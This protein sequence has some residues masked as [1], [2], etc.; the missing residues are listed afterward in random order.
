MA[1][2]QRALC[3]GNLAPNHY[4]D[5]TTNSQDKAALLE[6]MEREVKLYG[7]DSWKWYCHTDPARIRRRLP[8]RRRQRRLVLRGVAQARA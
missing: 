3:Q 4:W 1:G 8:A 2:S 7:I 6:Q 5:K